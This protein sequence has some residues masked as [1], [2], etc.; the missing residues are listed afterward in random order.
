[1]HYQYLKALFKINGK[2]VAEWSIFK[3]D[4]TQQTS[5]CSSITGENSI[6]KTTYLQTLLRKKLND[7]SSATEFKI[8]LIK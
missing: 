2:N 4:K 6:K 5:C 7:C 3:Y 8:L 1:M